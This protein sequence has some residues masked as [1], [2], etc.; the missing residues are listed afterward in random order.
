MRILVQRVAEASVE[1]EGEL[2]SSIGKGY[3]LL[4]GFGQEEDPTLWQKMAQKVTKLRIF[5]D[6]NGK[7]NLSLNDVDGEILCVS[8]FTLYAD[9]WTGNRPSFTKAMGADLAREAYIKFMDYLREV[10]PKV[11]G[12]IFQADMK[13]KLI[14]DGPFTII[15]DSKEM[16][17]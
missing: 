6:E 15:L 16:S 7:T 1:V 5:P 17:K 14:N 10:C 2:V 8:Q 9:P 13:V 12:G 3:L 4:V 11:Q